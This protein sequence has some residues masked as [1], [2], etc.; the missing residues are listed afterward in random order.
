MNELRKDPILDRWVV[1]SK[2]R[3]KRP[4]Q[5]KTPPEPPTD[6][7]RCFFCQGHENETPEEITRW[8][9]DGDWKIR[10]FPNKFKAT[11]KETE[12]VFT[13]NKNG[14]VKGECYGDHEIIVETPH[15]TESLKDLPIDHITEV[16]RLLASREKEHYKRNNIKYVSI[17][18]NSGKKAGASLPHTHIQLISYNILPTIIQNKL[19]AIDYSHHRDNTCP[20]CSLIHKE[21][22][23]DRFVA[24]HGNFVSLAPFASRFPFELIILPK[25]HINSMSS[26]PDQILADLAHILK[27]SLLKLSELGDIS[28]NLLF[29]SYPL[30]SSFHF[31]IEL[32][33]R[34]TT[35]AGF[36]LGTDTIINPMT[37]EDAASFYRGENQKG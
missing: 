13:T 11:S 15:H 7:S 30:N 29:F 32:C 24:E 6:S 4:D 9:K 31:H 33:P 2:D 10:V 34:I 12:G 28:Y 22:K 17:F 20:Y 36:E 19:D 23:T 25:N 37:P 26:L 14:M 35:W 1:I 3:G 16:L 27:D 8:P 21:S 18:K 5:F